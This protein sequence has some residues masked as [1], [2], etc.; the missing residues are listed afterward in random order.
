MSEHEG[1]EQRGV[2]PEVRLTRFEGTC[3]KTLLHPQGMGGGQARAQPPCAAA[4]G[5]QRRAVRAARTGPGQRGALGRARATRCVICCLACCLPGG[6]LVYC[7]LPPSAPLASVSPPAPAL[8]AHPFWKPHAHSQKAARGVVW[9]GCVQ[10]YKCLTRGGV[11]RGGGEQEGA[12]STKTRAGGQGVCGT[13]GGRAPHQSQWGVGGEGERAG[14]WRPVRTAR[15]LTPARPAEMT[16]RLAAT[17][18][19]RPAR[20]PPW[21][22][23]HPGRL[24]R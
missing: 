8:R 5:R 23:H 14:V 16:D 17:A 11:G 2:S 1:G 9:G 7:V 21:L 24:L 4:A 22:Q 15:P 19:L 3:T 6:T 10:Q 12:T 18:P 13:K 20:P